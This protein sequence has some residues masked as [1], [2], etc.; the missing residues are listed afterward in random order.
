MKLIDIETTDDVFPGEYV[1]HEPTNTM[2][3]CGSSNKIDNTLKVL[4]G[5]KLVEDSI[6]NFKKMSLTPEEARRSRAGRCKGCT[7]G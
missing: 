4:L 7:G 6:S 3:L 2:G 5:G 1:F